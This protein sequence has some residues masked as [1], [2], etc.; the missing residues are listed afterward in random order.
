M[1]AKGK[2]LVKIFNQST[3]YL[4]SEDTVIA[5]IQKDALRSLPVGFSKPG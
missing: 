1:F 5:F 3:Q 4:V 2:A